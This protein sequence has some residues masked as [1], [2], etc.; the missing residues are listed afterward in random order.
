MRATVTQPP[1]TKSAVRNLM[2]LG[3]RLFDRDVRP[4]RNWELEEPAEHVKVLA[5]AAKNEG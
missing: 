3:L 2:S 5:S 1:C 4:S